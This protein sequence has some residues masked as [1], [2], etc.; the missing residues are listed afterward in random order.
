MTRFSRRRFLTMAGLATL[1]LAAGVLGWRRRELIEW[2][3]HPGL[4]PAATG[5]LSEHAA[6]TMLAAAQALLDERVASDLYLDFFRWRAANAPGY[7]ALYA[8][9]VLAVDDAARR[10]GAADFARAPLAQRRRI[11]A[12]WRP[13]RR[14][15]R[16]SQGLL[17]REALRF[18]KF[19]VRDVFRLFSR[20]EAWTRT[21]YDFWPG[22]PRGL[23]G[24]DRPP[25]G[26]V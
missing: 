9:F 6:Q 12:R 2:L 16:L 26:A 20:T 3:W 13:R 22:T 19:V 18:S 5:T 8:R 21:G 24:L 15:S 1:G 25:R 4:A 14:W 10:T 17:G 7:R 11:L 23:E